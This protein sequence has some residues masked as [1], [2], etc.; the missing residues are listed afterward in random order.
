[1][2]SLL[3][4]TV[5]G[6]L[7]LVLGAMTVLVFASVVLR[8]VLNSPVTWSEELA[9]LLFAW[10]TFVGAYV[11]CRSRSHIAIDTLAVFVPLPVRR[12]IGHVVDVVVLCVLGLFVWQGVQLCITTWGLEF[13]ALEISRGYLY[14]SLPLGASLMIVAV[15]EHWRDARRTPGSDDASRERRP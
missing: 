6:V 14:L 2:R 3:D 10:I 11:G 5:N 8:Y 12:A 4:R 13:P 9:S 1:M 7:A 15:V